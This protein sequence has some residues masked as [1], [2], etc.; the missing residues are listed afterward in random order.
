MYPIFMMSTCHLANR[1]YKEKSLLE[2]KIKIVEACLHLK[3]GIP[4]T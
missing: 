4:K 3:S 2:F 1:N